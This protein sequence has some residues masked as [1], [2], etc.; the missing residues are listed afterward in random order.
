MEQRRTPR[1][2]PRG[3]CSTRH[4]IIVALPQGLWPSTDGILEPD[5][6][7]WRKFQTISALG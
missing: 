6:S 2:A 5:T 4:D 7:Q 3:V 1:W